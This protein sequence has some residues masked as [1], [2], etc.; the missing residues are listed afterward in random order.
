LIPTIKLAPSIYRWKIQLSIYPFYKALLELER[1]AFGSD[2]NL[3]K[4]KE[5]MNNLDH[6]EAKLSKIK[7]PAVFADMFYGLRGHINFVRTR[8]LAEQISDATE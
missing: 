4:R 8:L 7:I 6:L 3:D 1:D 5:I 2:L